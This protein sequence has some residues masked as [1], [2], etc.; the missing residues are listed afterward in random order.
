MHSRFQS[1]QTDTGKLDRAALDNELEALARRYK[2]VRHRSLDLCQP[3]QIEDFGVQP[4]ADASPPK[5]HL[6]HITW[7]FETF[8]LQ[9]YAANYASYNPAFEHLFNSYYN[10][11][12]NPFPRLK[13]GSLSRPTVAEIYAYRSNIDEALL[14]LIDEGEFGDQAASEIA[15]ILELGLHHEQQHQ[16]LL[17]TDIKY[18][19]GHNPLFP[20]YHETLHNSDQESSTP[21]CMDPPGPLRE[22]AFSEHNPGLVDIGAVSDFAFDNEYPRHK[23]FLGPF[24]IANRLVSNG[25]Y[26]QFMHDGGYQRADLWLAQGWA[27]LQE[28]PRHR[29]LYWHQTGHGG[30]SEYRMDGLHPLELDA[31]VTHVSGYEAMA[32]ASWAGARLPTEFEWEWAASGKALAGNFA[33]SNRFHPMVCDAAN[34]QFFG[35]VWEWTS[36]AYGPYPGYKPLEGVLGEYNGKFMSSQLVLRGGSCVTAS[37]HIRASYRNFFY[38]ADSWQFSGIRLAVDL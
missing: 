4:M 32:Y 22:M 30:W 7:F 36:S 23:S 26:L 19:L 13:R 17:L 1:Y 6:A 10:G 5:W 11:V 29:P 18:N 21:L 25:E 12:G 34:E 14:T 35:D 16:E 9:T 31:P 2:D 38:P 15:Q 20:K 33:D 3:L 37:S 24:A 27:A 28:N 8:L